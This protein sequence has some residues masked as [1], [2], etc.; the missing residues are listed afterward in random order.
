MYEDKRHIRKDKN[1]KRFEELQI[2]D[3]QPIEALMM[4]MK[5]KDAIE[6]AEF[7]FITL[8]LLTIL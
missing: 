6:K 3:S 7:N 1:D 4:R 5:T 8:H 2:H